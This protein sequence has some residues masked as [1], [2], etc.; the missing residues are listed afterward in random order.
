MSTFLCRTINVGLVRDARH[1]SP[2]LSMKAL[3]PLKSRRDLIDTLNALARR[4]S[5][6]LLTKLSPRSILL[7]KSSEQPTKSASLR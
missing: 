1:R 7:M 5:F 6:V 3:F 4:S 2:P